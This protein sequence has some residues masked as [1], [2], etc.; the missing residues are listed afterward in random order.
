MIKLQIGWE[1]ALRAA[2]KGHNHGYRNIPDNKT[3]CPC[4]AMGI[5]KRVK[6]INRLIIS[7]QAVVIEPEEIA[8]AL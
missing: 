7:G 1:E 4:S 6:E 3:A 8:E 5:E 2:F